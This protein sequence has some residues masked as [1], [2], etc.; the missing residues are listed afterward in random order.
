MSA[1]GL[2]EQPL[3]LPRALKLVNIV[4]L[5]QAL[6][7]QSS[8]SVIFYYNLGRLQYVEAAFLASTAHLAETAREPYLLRSALS[9]SL[10]VKFA[11]YQAACPSPC[12]G[13]TFL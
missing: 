7:C 9:N 12:A 4:V 6:A 5:A 8:R 2:L 11:P 3:E 10:Q 1:P 13:A